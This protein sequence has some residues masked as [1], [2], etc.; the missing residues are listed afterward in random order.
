MVQALVRKFNLAHDKKI[1]E[2]KMKVSEPP[3]EM[4]VIEID[5]DSPPKEK[6]KTDKKVAKTAKK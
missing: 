2:E 5:S 6:E 1:A 4:I 3:Q